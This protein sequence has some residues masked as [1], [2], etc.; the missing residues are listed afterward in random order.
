MLSK[1]AVALAAVSL[2]SGQTFSECNPLKKTCNPDPAFGKEGA[3]C[4]FTTGP[5]DAFKAMAGKDVK[6]DSKGALAS[7]DGPRQAPTLRSDK[8]LFFGRIDIEMQAAPGKGII[9]SIV[10]QSDT[11]DEIDFEHIGSDDKQ[12]QSNYFYKGDTT[13]Y[14]RGGFHPVN[15]PFGVMHTYSF[16][17]TP[18]KIDWIINGAVV[19]TLTRAAVGD[20]YPQS[21]M[22]VKLGA[23]VAGFE[24]NDPGTIAWSGGIAD[25]SNGPSTAIYKSI[26]IV[27]YAG[28]SSATDKDVKEYVYSDNSGSASSIKVNLKDG[29]GSKDGES[30]SSSSTSASSTA[31]PP[32]ASPPTASPPTASPTTASPPTSSSSTSSNS[33]ASSVTRTS[34]LQCTRVTTVPSNPGAIAAAANPVKLHVP[35]SNTTSLTTSTTLRDFSTSATTVT[36]PQVAAN[37]AAGGAVF[38]AASLLLAIL[39][40]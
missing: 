14:D 30:A 8:Y 40:I 27:D 13:T 12:V 19:R 20:N 29:S 23:W 4:D 36:P 35:D 33:E 7:M 28:G 25:F 31:S 38:G 5:C 10:L 15:D 34:A 17:W 11:L 32:T 26:K 18:D 22:Q 37:A 1:V 2:V 39:A 16:E 24:G 3:S 6:F 21:P 9:S